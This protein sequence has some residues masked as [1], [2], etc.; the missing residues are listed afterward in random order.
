MHDPA[1]D[2]DMAMDG[3]S[4]PLANEM[5]AD[6][7]PP[8]YGSNGVRLSAAVLRDRMATARQRKWD[9][10]M[11]YQEKTAL[12]A[13]AK[14]ELAYV[15]AMAIDEWLGSIPPDQLKARYGGNDMDRERNTMLYLAGHENVRQGRDSVR[16][17]EAEQSIAYA[18]LERCK[19][20]VEHL[21]VLALAYGGECSREAGRLEWDAA[22][23]LL[24]AEA[25]TKDAK[26]PEG[27]A[28]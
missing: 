16:N 17:L 10:Y 7:E 26:Y 22:I 6:E 11:L 4:E 8:A 21:R 5:L 23:K 12:F 18:T 25:T 19:E 20:E 2:L 3:Y 28:A 27:M 14:Q 13:E 9:A 24:N 1:R 15:E